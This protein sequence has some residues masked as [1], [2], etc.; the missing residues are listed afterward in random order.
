MV[1]GRL[2][3]PNSTPLE[4]AL[5]EAG[6]PTCESSADIIRDL[7]DPQRCPAELLPWLAW[8]FSVDAWD[9]A[10][11]ETRKRT[12]VAGS[13]A[14][15]RKKGTP[16]AVRQALAAIGYPVINLIEYRTYYEEWIAAGGRTLDGSWSTDG[17]ITL[18]PPAGAQSDVRRMALSH[19]AEYAIRINTADGPWDR[20]AQRRIRRTAQAYAPARS[21]LRSIIISGSASIDSTV[22]VVRARDRLRTRFDRCKRAAVHGWRTLDGCWSLSSESAPRHIDGGWA[23]DGLITLSGTQ[24]IGHALDSSFGASTDR[25]RSAFRVQAAGGDRI[26]DPGVLSP[27]AVLDGTLTLSGRVTDGAWV[28][29]GTN[30]LDY[31][32]LEKFGLRRLDGTWSLG[33]VAGRPG[34]WFT[35]ALTT[36]RN[37]VITKEVLQ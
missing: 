2:L 27:M 26:T 8:A 24:P 25:L 29:D 7:W 13:L 1:V 10:W 31:P 19:W 15:H 30:T 14:W 12:V 4:R 6:I 34:I 23:L 17:S 22:H 21:R 33:R 11:D 9:D 36:R 28:L 32:T 3:P 35:A 37:G 20:A 5:A 18:D 16:W